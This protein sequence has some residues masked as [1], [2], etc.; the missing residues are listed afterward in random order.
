VPAPEAPRQIG[1]FQIVRELGRGG[2][3]IVFLA[4]DPQLRREVALKVPR[5][6]TLLAPELRERF[7]REARVAAGLDHPNLVSIYEAGAAGPVC[8]IASAYCPGVT[9]AQWLRQQTEP[10]PAR[11]AAVLCAT[12]AGA[13]EHAHTHGVVHRDLK[14][15]NVLLSNGGAAPQAAPAPPHHAALPTHQVRITDFGLAKIQG[16]DGHTRTGTIVGTPAY[17]APEQAAPGQEVVGPAADVYALGAILYELLTG[18]PPFQGEAPLDLLLLVRTEEPVAPSRLRPHLPRAIE[19][20]CLKCLRKQP[21]QRYASAGAL[22]QDLD[23]FLA[24]QPI[25]A[26]PVGPVGRFALWCR[27]KPALALVSG[28][29]A[30]ALMA[31]AVVSVLFGIHKASALNESEEQLRQLA[32]TNQQLEQTDQERR[33]FIRRSAVQA[34]DRALDLCEQGQVTRGL[35]LL[36]FSLQ[37]AEPQDQELQRTIRTNL[38]AWAAQVHP[39]QTILAHPGLAK[40]ARFSP[41]GRTVVTGGTEPGARVWEA[42]TGRL[43]LTLPR[44]DATFAPVVVDGEAVTP[45]RGEVLVALFSPDGKT[46]LT[47]GEGATAT[48]WDATT[49][50]PRGL[51]LKHR[52]A[53]RA[54]AFSPDGKLVLTAGSRDQTARLWEVATGQPVGLP[55]RHGNSIRSVAFSPVGKTVATGSL[56]QTVRLWEVP[57]GRPLFGPLSHDEFVTALAFNPDGTRLLASTASKGTRIWDVTTGRQ[58]G[59]ALEPLRLHLDW[60]RTFHVAF[61]PDGQ[62]AFTGSRAQ[63]PQRWEVATGKP[64]GPAISQPGPFSDVVM[65]PDGTLALTGGDDRRARLWEL[66]TGKPL[67][68]YLTHSSAVEL[69]AFDP[70]GETFL[71]ASLGQGPRVFR[72]APPGAPGVLSGPTPGVDHLSFAANGKSL[73]VAGGGSLAHLGD[74]STAE[75][76]LKVP[77]AVRIN[78]TSFGLTGPILAKS[79]AKLPPVP[80]IKTAAFSPNGQMV[81]TGAAD[82]TVHFWDLSTR[83]PT[84][85]RLPHP[86]LICALAFSPDGT[87]LITGCVDHSARVWDVGTGKLVSGPLRHADVV[88]S[89]AFS[90]DGKTVATASKDCTARL[91]EVATGQPRGQPLQH[92]HQVTAVTFSPDGKTVLTGGRDHRAQLWDAASGAPIAAPLIHGNSLTSVAFSPDGR[93][94]V[95]GVEDTTARLWDVALGKPLGPGFVHPAPVRAVVF[96]PDGKSIA[97]GCYYTGTVYRWPAPAPLE[98]DLQRIVL[99]IEVLTGLELDATGAIRELGAENWQERRRRLEE[100][101]GPP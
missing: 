92:S 10:V 29:A 84:P 89:V 9:L 81:A 100:R 86:D 48:L 26:R 65:S 2:Y 99:W 56:D 23:R 28:L 77:A 43:V 61:T 96:S 53:V 58:L 11:D 14:P 8:Y 39:V 15:A 85:V 91:W 35:I 101:G 18:R 94:I 97:T 68:S 50:E 88:Y 5:T 38:R 62:T 22:G 42:T 59:P 1:R 87:M 27:R 64:L 30:L 41:D 71:T 13:V 12:L 33:R 20:I 55:M 52:S 32:S 82:C 63:G 66:A 80:W 72:I 37:L 46:I 75:I 21:H 19:T 95:T 54:A 40:V 90:P 6:E 17:M 83:N 57:S 51:P 67:G 78:T 49:G 44:K 73:L 74:D 76:A 4:T 31:T 24:G 34:L 25:R 16:E 98:G 93:T 69:V 7:L 45:H 70:K 60:D 79:L 47:A 3:G 36:T